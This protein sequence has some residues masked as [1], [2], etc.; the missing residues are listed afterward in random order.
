MLGVHNACEYIRVIQFHSFYQ[1]LIVL[2]DDLANLVLRAEMGE[3]A[4]I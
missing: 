3:H 4:L 1:V 2:V